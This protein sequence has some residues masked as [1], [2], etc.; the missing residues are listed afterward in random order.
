MSAPQR[1]DVAECF[2]VEDPRP[3]VATPEEMIAA[4]AK[5]LAG[6]GHGRHRKPGTRDSRLSRVASLLSGWAGAL[7]VCLLLAAGGCA[8]AAVVTTTNPR[9]AASLGTFVAFASVVGACALWPRRTRVS[10]R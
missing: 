1:V 5:V 8:V 3:R 6:R 2:D 10:R 7:R 4:A 9:I